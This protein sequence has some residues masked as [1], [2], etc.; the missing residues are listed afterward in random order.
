[1]KKKVLRILI[2]VLIAVVFLWLALKDVSRSDLLVTLNTLTYYWV[3][4]YIVVTLSSHYLRAERWKLLIE[5]E[6]INPSR[7]TLFSGVML[8]Y[9]VNYAV[10]RL[11]EISRSVFVGNQEQI[12]RTKLI[13]TVVMERFLD[14]IVMMLLILF[15]IVYL[16]SDYE[17]MLQ[18]V[19]SDYI[20]LFKMLWSFDGVIMI[21]AAVLIGFMAMFLLYFTILYLRRWFPFLSS[22]LIFFADV[23]NKFGQG[24]SSIKEI[25]NWPWFIFL[26]L[27]IWACYIIMT[28]LPFTAFN[29]HIQYGL[30][31]QEALII[32]T[33][34]AL[35]VTLPS[36]GGIGTYH[37]FV[38][39]SL[40]IFF[41]VPEALGL[42]YAIVTH[43]VMMI[44]ILVA[45]P[46]LLAVNKLV[47]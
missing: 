35:G 14:V 47:K 5:Q 33:V 25:R 34:S 29:M 6:G 7:M 13:G 44:I 1:M 32:T 10:P 4:P 27:V 2:S 3:V 24:L 46:I 43:L 22:V 23:F 31:F 41:A 36:P 15:V 37:W 45:T 19:G 40:L 39:R 28:Y 18:I 16:V 30:G 8:G 42:A 9:S 17:M 26:T 11:G 12:S 38:S 21:G 20:R